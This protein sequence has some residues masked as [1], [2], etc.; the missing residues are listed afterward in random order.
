MN[1]T[2]SDYL[3]GLSRVTGLGPVKI[4]KFLEILGSA[5]EFWKIDEADLQELKLPK[6]LAKSFLHLRS[7]LDLVLERKKLNE[8]GIQILGMTVEGYPPLLREIYDPPV[9]LYVRGELDPDSAKI[10]VVGTRI[11]TVY[12]RQVTAALAGELAMSGLTIVSGL[13]RGVDALAHRTALEVGGK[14]VAVL[15]SGLDNVYPAENR[16]LAEKIVASG[17]AVVSEYPP[18]TA[19]TVGTFP[20]RNRIIAGLSEGVLVTE[21]GEDSGSL[22]TANA[23]ADQ[24][25]T[26]FGVPGSIFSRQSAGTN[27]LLK[28][29]AKVVTGSRDILEELSIE[30]KSVE[31]VEVKPDNEMEAAILGKVSGEPV[32]FDE[33]VRNT[34]ISSGELGAA[35][36]V[37]VISGKLIDLGGYYAKRN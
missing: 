13:A 20:A 31:M 28:I 29:G 8:S 37:M 4:K 34:G 25:R 14:T 24:G 12:G 15:G 7:S 22:I 35:L 18:E 1:L 32:H 33:L 23:A 16:G 5:E 3:L 10:G 17:G 6:E 27:E 36:T 9:V 26:V 2:E 21:A 30:Y 11:M 19:A